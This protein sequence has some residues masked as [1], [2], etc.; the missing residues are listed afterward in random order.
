MEI[1]H[2]RHRRTGRNDD[3]RQRRPQTSKVIPRKVSAVEKSKAEITCWT[4]N[5][6]GHYSSECPRKRK[7]ISAVHE[8]PDGN[9]EENWQASN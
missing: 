7:V 6:K 5:K 8:A 1:D 9:E 3:R 2:Y 4:S